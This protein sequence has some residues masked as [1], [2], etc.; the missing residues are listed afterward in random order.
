MGGWEGILWSGEVV[1]AML[2]KMAASDY[3]TLVRSAWEGFEGRL[4]GAT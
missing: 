3:G 2:V 1:W 4:C